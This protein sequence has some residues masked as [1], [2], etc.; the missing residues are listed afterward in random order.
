[1]GS[2]A[3]A[4]WELFFIHISQKIHLLA[5]LSLESS[6]FKNNFTFLVHKLPILNTHSSRGG[7]TL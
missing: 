3:S 6:I 1:M 4:F 5:F 7:M 2:E